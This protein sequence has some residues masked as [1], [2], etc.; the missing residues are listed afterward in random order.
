VPLVAAASGIASGSN[1][2]VTVF[3]KEAV[4]VHVLPATAVQPIQ[5]LN[6]EPALGVAVSVTV[7]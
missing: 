1:F 6:T 2:A 4:T 7:A 5:L 3:P